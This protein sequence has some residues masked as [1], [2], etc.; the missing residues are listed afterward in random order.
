MPRRSLPDLDREELALLL[1][2]WNEPA[3]RV[4][5]IW[6][7]VY[8]ELVSS[9]DAI[10]TL[11]RPL[12]ARLAAELPLDPLQAAE[13]LESADKRT[14]K[15]LFRLAD[16]ETI[17]AVLMRY[18]ARRTVCLST[19]VG[20]AIGCPFCA[21]GRAGFRRD[22]TAGEIVSQVLHFARELRVGGER[23]TNVVYMGMGEPFL[24]YEATMKSIRLLNDPEGFGLRAR[25]FTVSTAGIVPGIERLA[26]EDIEV[27][28]AVSLHAGSDRLRNALVPVNRRYLLSE[29]IHAC[30]V[31]VARTR[32]R[33]TFEVALIERVNDSLSQAR[34]I[35]LLLEGLLAHVNLIPLNPV[36]GS[37]LRPSPPGRRAAFARELRGA[38]IPVTLRRGRGIE[39]E[40]GCGQLRGRAAAGTAAVSH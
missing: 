26:S 4:G 8:R 40:A 38:G 33:V 28:L 7:A 21:T 31:Y 10:T 27:N 34:E 36:P 1:A 24:N 32:R 2:G 29:V 13:R 9:Y 12:R 22:L 37:P 16:G 39:I 11:P 35:A 30:R 17:E 18:D 15:V 20:C 19:Q 6:R 3:F 23:P 5:Q 25:G 14:E